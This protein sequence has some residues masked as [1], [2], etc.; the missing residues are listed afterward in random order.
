MSQQCPKRGFLLPHLNQL[1]PL[2][3][4]EF[5]GRTMSGLPYNFLSLC[6]RLYSDIPCIPDIAR[7]R[8]IL[9]P[10]SRF[11]F[12]NEEKLPEVDLFSNVSFLEY[13]LTFYVNHL[14]FLKS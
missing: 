11:Y 14:S 8:L 4:W 1:V 5:R 12:I 13:Y 6:I 3:L 7:I 10:S 9:S 2:K